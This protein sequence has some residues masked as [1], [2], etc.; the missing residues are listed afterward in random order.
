MTHLYDIMIHIS[1][2]LLRLDS[3]Q[4]TQVFCNVTV[5]LKIVGIRY[6]IVENVYD[7]FLM[8]RL[9]SIKQ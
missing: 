4:T 9:G 2:G 5:S 6:P 8:R 1:A 3:A 7:A